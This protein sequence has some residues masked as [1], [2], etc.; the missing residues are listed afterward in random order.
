MY[1]SRKK[2]SQPLGD[3]PLIVLAAGN[4]LAR[5]SDTP[6]DFWNELQKEND[7]QKADLAR[8]SRNAKLVRDPSSG[9]HIHVDNPELVARSIAEVVQAASQGT[10]FAP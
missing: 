1:E 10:R 5:S 6:A 2:T 4:T 8:L 9:H 7:D 3:L